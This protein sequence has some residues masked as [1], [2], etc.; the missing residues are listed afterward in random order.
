MLQRIATMSYRSLILRQISHS[1]RIP[2]SI[3][4]DSSEGTV[5]ISVEARPGSKAD[6]VT[7][8]DEDAVHISVQARPR[9]GEANRGLIE[10]IADAVGVDESGVT[11]KKGGKQ[12]SK[13]VEVE[14]TTKEEVYRRLA[15]KAGI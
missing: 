8:I 14:G 15:K 1:A 10:F 3:S 6:E 13:V 2:K 5:R 11:I 7:A 9:G 12:R 4:S